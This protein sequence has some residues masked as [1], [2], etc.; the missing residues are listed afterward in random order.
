MQG[1]V[2]VVLVLCCVNVGGLMMARVYARQREFSVRTA[3]GAARWRLMRQYLTES[4]V[5]ATSGAMLG[6]AAAWFG[7]PA[8]LRFFRDPMMFEAVSVHPDATVFW[9]TGLAAVATT[10]LC[11]TLPA[12]RAGRSDAGLLLNSRRADGLRKQVAGRAFIP[13]QA[14][15][16]LVLVAIATLLSQSLV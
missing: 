1:L 15:L 5:I 10:L 2:F 12:L 7:S 9:I 3:I 13:V 11:G 8:L 6:G 16:S 14:G 4:F